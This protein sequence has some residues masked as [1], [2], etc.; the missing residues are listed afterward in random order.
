MKTDAGLQ[1]LKFSF[2][3]VSLSQIDRDPNQPR[4]TFNG[5]GLRKLAESIREHSLI[6]LPVVKPNPSIDGRYLIVA[7]ERRI[8]ALG[9]NGVKSHP[10]IIVSGATNTFRWSLVENVQREDLNPIEEAQ[11]IN[12][13][14][15]E[16]MTWTQIQ[17]LTGKHYVT[18]SSRIK[19][20]DLPEEIQQMI[21]DG[22]LPSLQN[23]AALA[24]YKGKDTGN[25]IRMAHALIA[26]EELLELSEHKANRH[27]DR[28]TRFIPSTPAGLMHKIL[29]LARRGQ[30]AGLAM[31]EFCKL[32][33]AE[34][35]AVWSKLQPVT[36][37]HL[38]DRNTELQTAIATFLDVVRSL[39]T[40]IPT[41]PQVVE[42]RV[43]EVVKPQPKAPPPRTKP[44]KEAGP[45]VEAR[46]PAPR[47]VRF[48]A[49]KS[50]PDPF[51][52][53]IRDKS[54]PE[55]KFS[56]QDM[57]NGFKIVRFFS[58]SMETRQRI[59]LS[60]AKLA[61]LLGDGIKPKENVEKAVISGLKVVKAHWRSTLAEA[62]GDSEKHQFITMVSRCRFDLGDRFEMAMRQIKEN[63]RSPDP[64][65]IELLQH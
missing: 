31:Q 59:L 48:V 19:L 18:L 10:F 33:E 61:Q 43:V 5:D 41:P 29:D 22:K 50:D 34:R 64:I 17:T 60:K 14:R 21:V 3:E 56:D 35:R 37:R 11:S 23:A 42:K 62:R 12:K 44:S 16:G 58:E 38:T 40:S 36:R 4:Q 45:P 65:N 9:M 7:G 20:L 49:W 57:R 1:G 46:P 32:E 53:P 28:L 24:Q 52:Q 54:K 2:Q 39:N 47:E 15:N 55:D 27:E 25:L 30:G 51:V 13:C 26:G 8:R 6:Q 63:D